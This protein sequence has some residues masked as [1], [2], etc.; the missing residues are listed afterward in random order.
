MSN[1]AEDE[2][3]NERTVAAVVRELVENI[4]RIKSEL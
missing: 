4:M 3:T 2:A 1:A